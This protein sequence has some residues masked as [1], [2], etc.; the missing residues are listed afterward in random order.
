MKL[1]LRCAAFTLGL[2]LPQAVAAQVLND[3]YGP[4][5]WQVVDVAPNDVLNVRM[6]PGTAYPVVAGLSHDARGIQQETC[7]PLMTFE[8]FSAMSQA[9]HAALPAR[10]CLVHS[11]DQ[12][13]RGWVNAGFLVEDGSQAISAA[14][15]EEQGSDLQQTDRIVMAEQLV[16]ELYSAHALAMRGGGPS[17]LQLPKASDF[18]S[19][20]VAE[21]IDP[22]L[23]GADPLYDAQDSDITNLRIAAD[24]EQPAFRGMITIHA[25]FLNFG[26]PRRVTFYLRSDPDRPGA[27]ILIFRVEYEEWEIS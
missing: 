8:Q 14:P 24:P 3:G 20:N 12:T 7:V 22:A 27:P 2:A 1:A 5:G 23:V 16:R 26:E 13:I 15:A 9:D 25:D 11:A 21:E 17:P 6:G 19:D 10:W 18:F 4:D